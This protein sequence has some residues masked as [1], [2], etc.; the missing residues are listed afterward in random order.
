MHRRLSRGRPI[1]TFASLL[2]VAALLGS[3]TQA[4]AQECQTRSLAFD[5]DQAGEWEPTDCRFPRQCDECVRNPAGEYWTFDATAGDLVVAHLFRSTPSGSGSLRIADSSGRDVGTY[6]GL[7]NCPCVRASFRPVASGTYRMSVAALY[8]HG[9]YTIR[10]QRVTVPLPGDWS[11]RV[12]GNNAHLS[13][14]EHLSLMPVLEYVLEVGSMSG[15]SDIG[16]LSLGNPSFPNFSSV[17]REF[18]DVPSGTYF[19]RIR[20]R[21]AHGW[22]N[23]TVEASFTAT[24]GPYRL[25]VLVSPP[26]VTLFWAPPLTGT[27]TSYELLVGSVPGATDLGIYGVGLLRSIQISNVPPGTYYVRVRAMTSAGVTEPSNE[28]VARVPGS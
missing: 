25:N 12:E 9:P 26:Y 17:S 18:R 20:A 16:V 11:V 6:L 27:P 23:A 10:L 2:I 19:V 13:W 8:G 22:G 1:L 7:S 5:V 3:A 15:A 14:S 21:S 4:S 24:R 28:V